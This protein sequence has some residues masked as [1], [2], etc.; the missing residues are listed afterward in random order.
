M[1][2]RARLA[3]PDTPLHVTQR[4]N[5]RC[6]C[7]VGDS[8]RLVYL[9]LLEQHTRLHAV[10]V[11]AYVLMTNH[12]HLLVTPQ[13][14]DALGYAMR[15]VNQRYAQYFNRRYQRTGTLW[16]NRPHSCLVDAEAYLFTCHRYIENNPVRAGMVPEPQAYRW[17]SHRA[18]ALGARDPLVTP[19]QVVVALGRSAEQ[20]CQEYRRLFESDED[21]K[22]LENVRLMTAAGLAVGRESFTTAAAS[23]L[24]RPTALGKPGRPRRRQQ[25]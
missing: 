4:G 23:A 20:R 10:A 7:F 21:P 1:P 16:E 22:R 18:N 15:H 8:D 17:S 25:A 2:R 11:H 13:T 19:H 6:A 9:D 14:A 3:I 5:N 12:V 24:G